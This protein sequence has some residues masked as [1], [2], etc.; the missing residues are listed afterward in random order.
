VAGAAEDSASARAITL[1]R[2]LIELLREHLDDQDG[3]FVFASPRRCW[4]RRSDFDR[5]VCRPAV[6][7]TGWVNS[8]R[9]SD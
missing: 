1:P 4:L 5:R 6:P 7:R 9:A 8:R 2:F 3:D